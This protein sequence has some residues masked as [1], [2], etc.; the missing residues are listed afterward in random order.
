M[1]PFKEGDFAPKNAWYVAG[2]A[3]EA[4]E[5][6]LQ[7]WFLG[8]PVVLYRK[9]DGT[10]VAVGG[11]CPHRYFPLGESIRVGDAIQCG[12]HGITFGPDGN[13]TRVPS[14]SIVPGVYKIPTYPLVERGLWLWIW[15]GE[16]DKA[17]DSLIPTDEEIGFNQPGYHYSAF[18]TL[19]VGGRY[20]L[21][22]DN[23]LDLTHLGFLHS[24]SIG[25][26]D[27]ASTPEIRESNDRRIK[28]RRYLKGA[29][30][31]PLIAEAAAYDGLIDRVAGMDFFA[32]GFH[33]GL[34]DTMIAQGQ[35][36]AGSMLNSAKVYHAVTPAT[37]ERT[38][39][40]FAFGGTSPAQIELFRGALS[41]VV[42]EDVF[43]T[44]EI[45]KILKDSVE[46]PREL[47]IKSDATAVEGRRLIQK[48]M[49]RERAA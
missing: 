6:L 29:A 7:R 4:G 22:N 34:D 30:C 25:T 15:M 3:H 35:P 47:I 8:H 40:F 39:Y 16:P 1:Y 13:C 2:F 19:D 21:L 5:A 32:P 9:K 31:P 49:D 37:R 44:E 18:Y 45:E 12:Y 36:G 43:A 26:D 33:A 20:Q 11:R 23:L 17:D 14:Q 48:M 38:H 27:N 10:A 42:N 24:S 41:A 28:S 46:L